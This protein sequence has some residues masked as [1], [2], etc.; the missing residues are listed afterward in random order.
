MDVRTAPLLEGKKARGSEGGMGDV[1]VM[2]I[3]HSQNLTEIVHSSEKV[4]EE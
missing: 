4:V 1:R 3:A 2:C